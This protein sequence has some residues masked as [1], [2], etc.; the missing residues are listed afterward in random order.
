MGDESKLDDAIENLFAFSLAKR[1]NSSD[2]FWIHPLVH[3]WAREHNDITL[4]RKYA[5]ETIAL[6]AS[7]IV[8]NQHKKSSDDWIFERRILTHL[9]VCQ[10]HIADYFSG[11]NNIEVAHSSQVIALSYKDLGYYE[12][13]E[14][15]YRNTLSLF[16]KALG[17]DHPSTLDTVNNMAGIFD[18]QGRYDEAVK[19]YGRA[20]AGFQKALGNG[21]PS[22]LVTVREMVSLLNR[23][24]QHD[25]ARHLKNL[26]K[27]S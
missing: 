21:H 26:Y 20:L 16:E 14:E 5:E 3:A 10:K 8:T 7:A 27:L 4:Q 13:A 22:T 18:K 15:S 6:V 11:S 12:Q 19:W 9:G 23:Q 24:G 25:E 1:K 17:S 2:S